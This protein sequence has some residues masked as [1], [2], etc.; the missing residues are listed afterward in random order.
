M[1]EEKIHAEYPS[2]PTG[3]VAAVLAYAAF[4]AHD[5]LHPLEPS[6]E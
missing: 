6:P 2:L 5:E 3:A 1:T 4:L